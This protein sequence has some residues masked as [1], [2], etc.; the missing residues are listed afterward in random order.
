MIMDNMVFEKILVLADDIEQSEEQRQE[1][2][3]N[4]KKKLLSRKKERS[5][6]R[7]V[8]VAAAIIMMVLVVS[9]FM[10]FKDS[11]LVV[12]ASVSSGK[13]QLKTGEKISL[14]EQVTPLGR[15]YT[16]EIEIKGNN[17]YVTI[18][19]EKNQGLDNIFRDDNKIYWLPDGTANGNF[20]DENGGV[21]QVPRTDKSVL[22]IKV[23][24]GVGKIL[25]EVLLIMERNGENC[26]V[27]MINV[28][29]FFIHL[30]F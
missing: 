28:N 26:S 22:K 11:E 14:K 9:Q 18:E 15:G 6:R 2:L 17:K 24:D 3:L 10:V 4:C 29:A 27:K 19:D 12:Y 8:T 23:V 7:Y 1:N 25:N 20:R 30:H 5:I 16:F 21:I 13:E